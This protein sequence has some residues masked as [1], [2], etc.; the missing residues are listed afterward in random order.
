MKLDRN[1]CD[2]DDGSGYGPF[3]ASSVPQRHEIGLDFYYE[4]FFYF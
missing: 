1:Q 4:L 2:G 3:G